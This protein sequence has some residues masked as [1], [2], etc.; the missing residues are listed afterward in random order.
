MRSYGIYKVKKMYEP[1]VIGREQLLYDLLKE[2]G[3]QSENL[4]EVQYLCDILEHQ[5]IDEA[6]I[7]NLGKVF[8]SIER[9]NKE[10]TLKH[11]V[12]GCIR[13]SLSDYSL[14]VVCD[15]SRMLDLDLFIALSEAGNR[16]FAV[17]DEQGEWGWLKPIKYTSN[18][19][20]A[21]AVIR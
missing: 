1:F 18:R 21:V 17:M 15:G 4:Q 5:A 9:G 19:A 2:N 11:P 8:N 12:K 3:K 14:N 20:Q 10:Y 16:F 13:I 7:T 6:I